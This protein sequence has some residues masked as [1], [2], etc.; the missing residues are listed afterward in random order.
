MIKR[1]GNI[2]IAIFVLGLMLLTA[3]T[4]AA[5]E[6]KDE[7]S[8]LFEQEQK[9]DRISALSANPSLDDYLIWGSANNPG[10]RA[11][12]YRWKASFEKVGQIG[13][14]DPTLSYGYYLENVE[15]RVGP[16]E[17]RVSLKQ[18]LPWPGT[19][20]NGTAAALANAQAVRQNYQSGQYRLYYQIKKAYY[21]FY[22]L[23]REISIL[24]DN[25]HLLSQ[26][27]AV[28]RSRYK[29]ALAPQTDLIKAQVELARLE[30][31]L[32]S[33]EDRIR[34]AKEYLRAIISLPDSIDLP[35]PDSLTVEL[36]ALDEDHIMTAMRQTNPDLKSIQFLAERARALYSQS[37][38][39]NLPQFSVGVD[40][41]TTGEAINRTLEDSGKDPWIIN[42]G[43]NIPIWFGRNK[44]RTGEAAARLKEAEYRFQ[45]AGARLTA[46]MEER[47]YELRDARRTVELYRDGLI[48]KSEQS[49]SIAY[50]AYQAGSLEFL[51]VLDAQRQLLEFN[52][53]L[54]R[55]GVQYAVII[56]EIE[57]LIGT[58][59]KEVSS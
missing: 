24:T 10:L 18:S 43:I 47:L 38:K 35:I 22:L 44:A 23:G 15:T 56:A 5:S 4:P 8:A 57:M 55:A 25:M 19:I 41:I 27:E 37:K 28:A 16:Q 48:A 53:E 36:P 12:F 39:T 14:P 17:H 26:W 51:S 58:D 59:I 21:E 20:G 31:R 6:K 45:D 50:K 34:P 33:L 1:D 49:L 52:L 11:A 3:S 32:N 46:V 54:E 42:L 2:I 40:Y 7:Y 13:L 29:A 9:F 30:N